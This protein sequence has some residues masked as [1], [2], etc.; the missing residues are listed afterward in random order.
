MILSAHGL[1]CCSY[2][3]NSQMCA[4]SQILFFFITLEPTNTDR[5]PTRPL[6]TASVI[7][8]RGRTVGQLSCDA[9]I[10]YCSYDSFQYRI[11]HSSWQTLDFQHTPALSLAYPGHIVWHDPQCPATLLY[12]NS[13]QPRAMLYTLNVTHVCDQYRSTHRNLLDHYTLAGN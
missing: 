7:E 2:L 5:L 10:Q 8:I 11:L 13:C 9:R 1:D 6:T 12:G 3:T 4:L